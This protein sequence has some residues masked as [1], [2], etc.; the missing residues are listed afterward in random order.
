MEITTRNR[1]YQR[2]LL[3]SLTL[4]LADLVVVLVRA[5]SQTQLVA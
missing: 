4:L 5:A 2:Y 1:R 3:V